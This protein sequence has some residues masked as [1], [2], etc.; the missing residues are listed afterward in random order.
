MKALSKV[1]GFV[2]VM[3]LVFAAGTLLWAR[4]HGF[5]ARAK[6]VAMEAWLVK[7]IRGFAMPAAVRQRPNPVA[8][9]PVA[10]REG[11]EHYADHCA[12]CHANDGSGQTD[13]GKG[14]YPPA[15]DMRLPATQALTDGEL[16]S[17]IENGVRFTG[18]PAWATGTPEGEEASWKLVHFI[19]HLPKLRPEELE[20]LEDLNPISMEKLRQQLEAER[21]LETGQPPPQRVPTQ[22]HVHP[23]SPR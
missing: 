4:S 2:I 22:P 23:A 16:F 20:D 10:I 17:V 21:F 5:S 1:I 6:P 8:A 3:A 18:M 9:S 14:L 12:V 7:R 19:R 13:I 11:L 15:P